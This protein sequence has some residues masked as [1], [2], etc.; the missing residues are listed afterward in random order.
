MQRPAP[1]LTW[2]LHYFGS[3]GALE[4]DGVSD[5]HQFSALKGPGSA[6]KTLAV[7][8]GWLALTRLKNLGRDDSPLFQRH[9]SPGM[10]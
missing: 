1:N 2:L 9:A 6:L 4:Q 7:T 5:A 8:E 3:C 10:L